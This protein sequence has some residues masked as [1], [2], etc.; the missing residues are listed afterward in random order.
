MGDY[1]GLVDFFTEIFLEYITFMV[2]SEGTK[3]YK[4]IWAET[5]Y[6]AQL[7]FQTYEEEYQARN[8]LSEMLLMIQ[9]QVERIAPSEQVYQ[10]LMTIH[11][12]DA[13]CKLYPYHNMAITNLY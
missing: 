11:H 10:L 8:N 6:L 3:F 13:K 7:F 9:N 12:I 4:T 1:N 2:Q 5:V